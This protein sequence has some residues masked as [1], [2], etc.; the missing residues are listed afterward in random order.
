MVNNSS[1]NITIKAL[2]DAGLN[3]TEI[4]GQ[5]QCDNHQCVAVN[6]GQN[7]SDEA[8]NI[9]DDDKQCLMELCRFNVN[10]FNCVILKKVSQ[11]DNEETDLNLI[12]T[13]RELQI[14]SLVALGCPNKQIADKLH[15]SEWTV[16]TYI[17]RMCDK[18]GVHTRAAMTY[19]CA[20]LIGQQDAFMK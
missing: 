11:Q 12:L 2:I 9:L 20:S 4:L 1:E 8:V 5:F 7:S 10:G 17:R 3:A 6:L 18:C 16:A 15:I 19:R 14:A 13:A